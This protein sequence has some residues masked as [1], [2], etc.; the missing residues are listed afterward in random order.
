M[1][2]EIQLTQGRIA[3]VDDEDFELVS[4]HKWHIHNINRNVCYATTNIWRPKPHQILLHRF[5][6]NP[7]IHRLV[8]HINGNGLDCRK[9]NMRLCTNSQNLCNRGITR[10]NTTGYKCV[11]WFARDKVWVAYVKEDGKKKY[12]GRFRTPEEAARAYDRAAKEIYGE[13]A[14]LNFPDD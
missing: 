3:L 8:D 2:K 11:Q 14:Y 13:F 4:Q 10:A 1:T 5:I 7:P 12:L 9:E 6:L